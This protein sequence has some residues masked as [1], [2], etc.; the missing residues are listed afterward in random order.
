VK[1]IEVGSKNRFLDNRLQVNVAAYHYDYTDQQVAT[2]ITAAGASTGFT[3]TINAGESEFW[4]VE[5]EPVFQITPVD[6]LNATVSWLDAEFTKFC[7][8]TVGGVCTVSFAGK[9]P[10]QA[11]RMQASLGFEHEFTVGAG[12]LT[13]RVQSSYESESFLVVQNYPNS[14]IAPYTRSD[15]FLTYKPDSGKWTVQGYVRNIENSTIITS[16]N[17]NFGY[18]SFGLAPPRTYGA[19]LT[20]DFD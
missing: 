9:T 7:T 6:R 19:R 4:G 1:S 10:V 18:Y 11:P 15:A 3:K 16:A 12:S 14:R 2:L 8:A 13:A 17:T 20:Y 5:V